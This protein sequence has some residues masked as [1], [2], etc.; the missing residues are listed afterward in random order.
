MVASM[1]GVPTSL[2]R[3]SDLEEIVDHSVGSMEHPCYKSRL[4]LEDGTLGFGYG[5]QREEIDELIVKNDARAGERKSESAT[6]RPT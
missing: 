2:E 3:T 1:R 4:W 5:I 6:A